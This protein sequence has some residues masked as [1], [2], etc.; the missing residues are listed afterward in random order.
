MHLFFLGNRF[1][2]HNFKEGIAIVEGGGM[3]GPHKS[4]RNINVMVGSQSFTVL[5]RTVQ[6]CS[7]MIKCSISSYC[8]THFVSRDKTGARA[9]VDVQ[10]L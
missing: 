6:M 9:H 3:G 4:G 2:A 1:F 7:A 10:G 8:L 5:V